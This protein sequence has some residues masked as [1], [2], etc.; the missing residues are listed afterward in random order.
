M[1]DECSSHSC[2]GI[3]EFPKLGI[4]DG[5]RRCITVVTTMD[6]HNA[7]RERGMA[8]GGPRYERALWLYN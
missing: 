7:C 2:R 6:R 5:V 1:S 3:L 8:F 4:A